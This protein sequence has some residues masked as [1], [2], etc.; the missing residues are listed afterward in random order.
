MKRWH[1]TGGSWM[2]RSIRNAAFFGLGLL[3]ASPQLAG[4]GVPQLNQNCVAVIANRSVQVNA[5]GTF[6]VPNIPADIGYYRVRV[7][8]Q[9]GGVTTQG[10]SPYITLVANGNS[11]V[12]PINFGTV[13][14]PPIS[15]K[16]TAP[17][18][19][20]TATGQTVQLTVIGTLI[21]GTT[22]DLS[23]QALGTLYISS[24]AQV[25]KVSIDGLVTAVG[26]GQAII[27]ARNEGAA[28]TF[29]L[30]VNIPVS[31]VGD[32]IPDSWKI[33]NGFSVTDP[34]VAGADPDNDGLTNLQE[35]QLGTNPNNPDTDGDGIPDGQE[36]K[37]GTNPL[38]PDTDG[39]GL[40]DGQEILLGTNP[41]NPD[42][43]GDGIPDGIEVK[44]GLNPL[45]PDPT[46][47]VQGRV[48]NGSNTPVAGA[49]VVLFGLITGVTDPTGFF[50]INFV[51]ADL[52]PITAIARVTLNN[53][54]L[55][56]ESG[57]T[58]PAGSLTNVGIIQLGQSNGSI[59]G[60]VT[61]VQNNPVTNAQVTINI[62][63]ETRSTITNASGLYAFSG[64]TPNSFVARAVDLVTGLNGQ[65]SGYLYA[66]SSAVANIQLS[67]SGAIKGTVFATN[68]TT[69][70]ANANVV[71]SGSALANTTT[72]ETG[73][74]SFSF[75][76]V[77]VFTLDATDSNGNRGRSTGSIAKTG[78][79]VQ[80]NVTFLG[81][82]SVSGVVTDSSQN[83]VANASVS[84][85][86]GSIF[87]GVS[88][89]TTDPA[90]HYALSGI[91]IGPYNVTASSSALK[92]GGQTS[93]NISS[94]QQSVTSNIILTAAGTVNGTI[95]HFD[96]ATPVSNA[97]VSLSGGFTTQADANGSYT[98]NF[99][100]LGTYTIS[101]TDPTNGDQ[102]TGSVTI[103]NQGQVQT[104]NVNLNGQGNVTVT[105]LDAVSNPD[106]SAIVTLTGQTLFGGTF[107][108]V[109]QANGTYAFSQVPAGA[110]AVSA[111]DPVTQAGAGPVSGS[112]TAGGSAAITLQLQPVGSVTGI[113]FAANGVTPVSGI[114]V[115]LVGGVTQ[116]TASASD[117][118]FLFNVVPSGT[119]TLQAVDG[120][121]SVRATATVTV[122]TEGSSV[123][124]NLILVGF[125]TVTGL[126]SLAE[127]PPAADAVVT[128]TDVTGKT[129][130]AL[131]D[132][133]GNYSVSQVAVG[134]FT[135]QALFEGNGRT[136]SGFVQSLVTADAGTTVANIQLVGTSGFM[137]ATLYDANG[138]PYNMKP[139]GS[140][141]PGLNHEFRSNFAQLAQ[142]AMMLE[143]ISGG[144]AIPFPGNGIA[145]IVSNG[146][147]FDIQGNRSV[148]GLTMT[149]KIYVPRDGYFARYIDLL[150]NPTGSPVT[151][152]L[153][154]T[155]TLRNVTRSGVTVP[156]SV[157]AT[158]SGNGLPNVSPPNPDHWAIFDDDLDVDPFLDTDEN[159]PPVAYV[160]D[161][162]GAAIQPASIQWTLNAGF[163]ASLQEEFDG[164]AVP[165]G[166]QIAV[167]HFISTQVNRVGALTSAQR[168]VQL[169]PEGLASILPSDLAAIQNFVMPG[170]GVST[171]NPLESL[172]GQ[173][174][175]RVL[176]G[177]GVTPVT[178]SAVSFQSGEPLF[179]RTWFT[180]SD[181]NGNYSYVAQFNDLGGSLPVPIAPFAVQAFST[182]GTRL[183]SQSTPGNFANG[184]TVAVQ[185]IIF[186]ASGVLSGT[187][188]MG[189][190]SPATSGTIQIVS[191]DSG[192]GVTLYTGTSIAADGTY[193]I[194]VPAGNYDLTAS[195]PNAQGGPPIIGATTATV[196]QGQAV[197]ANITLE[198]TGSVTGIVYGLDGSPMPNFAVQLET[199]GGDYRTT[200]DAGGNFD[201]VVVN[202]GTGLLG[203]YDPVTQ[204]GAGAAVNV[205]A[206]QATNQN[207]T[208]VQ[209]TGS[210]TG[211]VTTFGSPVAGIPVRV[212][213]VN[214]ATTSTT[215]DANGNYFVTSV[216]VGP[217]TVVASGGGLSGQGQNFLALAGTTVT[218]N[219]SVQN[220]GSWNVPPPDRERIPG[221]AGS[222]VSALLGFAPFLT[223]ATSRRQFGPT[224]AM[225]AAT[226]TAPWARPEKA[227]CPAH[228]SR[229]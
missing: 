212:T 54:I 140:L 149:R 148:F 63:A 116:T 8:C 30:S 217:I 156:P 185:D 18:Q 120:S 181:G 70:F 17:S 183:Q 98:L 145:S 133:A 112:V 53:V 196:V 154:Y 220:Q 228:D 115:N 187:V 226:C 87:G 33:A 164:I 82:G 198:A 110:F 137:P 64:F 32:G 56:G 223:E 21:N 114:T 165:V 52:G 31:T 135:A 43:D 227:P 202:A 29:A 48:L 6:A 225:G 126:V 105:V 23:T 188:F 208:L 216:P 75:V 88:T 111:S 14:P 182:G 62:G 90:G 36:V 166:G 19:S 4:Q 191:H 49:S 150:Q 207:L 24:N 163:F 168:L 213:A 136:E 76:P 9:N 12:P 57:P 40:P 127:G 66:N 77:G 214:G 39:D 65:T 55:E 34:G 22:A 210:V 171:L 38:N 79:I 103:S 10:Q 189:N 86:S 100:P 153:R 58:N 72:N 1:V 157:V 89:T 197:T 130:I 194:A 159:I 158:S 211:T 95:F 101:V 184:A 215:T 26:R 117:G 219:V 151:V 190:G 192:G 206:N 80:S 138:L 41:L 177:D 13:T 146:R 61:N 131:S 94:D 205:T 167:L 129:Q 5:N 93:G 221:A 7:I 180:K 44:L 139:D 161:G 69:P 84:L 97:Q 15:I 224:S 11:K 78:S 37:L 45:V 73:Q 2:R 152:G 71:L 124:Q 118:S 104:V 109:T 134:T 3:A 50:S 175:G 172:N 102:G 20:F 204:S 47:T 68:G 155:S 174:M 209:G 99:V 222:S 35:Y 160:F 173:V 179:A 81:K 201:F 193:R 203:A 74:F 67:A 92:L 169:P 16:V 91:Y 85:N 51:P 195:Q 123:R 108:G 27:T 143:V 186:T 200:T 119:Y 42:S 60:V 147:E 178:A 170:G 142:G 28:A 122:A 144:S 132:A 125:G 121:G 229:F 46:T 199:A 96:G 162:P 59:S 83:P 107:N 128:V 176:A 113:V 218:I 25:A 141:D 106:A